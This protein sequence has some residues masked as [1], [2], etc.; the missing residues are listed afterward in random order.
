MELDCNLKIDRVMNNNVILAK[1]VDSGEEL[2]LLGKGIGFSIKTGAWIRAHDPRIEKRFRLDDRDQLRQNQS[3]VEDI[4]PEVI[5]I[6]EEIICLIEL[7]FK[8]KVHNKVYLA[9][10]SHIKFAIFRLRNGM[11]ILNPFLH[12][13]KMCYPKE[14]EIAQKAAELMSETFNIDIPEDEV[15]FLTFHVYSALTNVPVSQL[16]KF[17]NFIMG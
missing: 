9:L 11:D 8:R 14:F 6:S 13:T 12:E 1:D 17:S 10:P 4:E 7:Q 16:T 3:L 5:H 15:G 2:V